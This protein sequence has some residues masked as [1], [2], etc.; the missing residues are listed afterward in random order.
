MYINSSYFT[1]EDEDISEDIQDDSEQYRNLTN[2]ELNE[3]VRLINIEEKIKTNLVK[4]VFISKMN[5]IV[6]KISNQESDETNDSE[7]RF[8][9]IFIFQYIYMYIYVYIYF[10][11]FLLL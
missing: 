2:N 3:L 9:I 1:R 11:F 4:H 8:Y 5:D 10:F 6:K 7:G